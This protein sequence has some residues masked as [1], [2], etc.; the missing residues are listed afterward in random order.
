MKTFA[1]GITIG[2]VFGGANAFGS[3]LKSTNMLNSKLQEL[4]DKRI[5]LGSKFG[6]ASNEATK[7]NSTIIGLTRNIKLM[8][9]SFNLD[10][11]LSEYRKKFKESFVDKLALGTSIVMPFKVA[12]DFESAMADVKK[13]VNFAND[14]EFKDFEKS[15]LSLSQTIPLSATELAT[16]SASGGQLGIAKENLLE[17]TTTVAKMSTAFDMSA[18]HAGDSIAKLMNIYGL[19][20]SQIVE[21]GDSINHL[22]DTSASK[23]SD[24]VETLGRIG[25]VAKIFGLTTVQA[26]ALSSAFLSLGKPPEVAATSINALLLKLQTADK[27]GKS[28]N[29]GLKVLGLTAKQLKT[30]IEDNPQEAL[31][32]FLNT[33]KEVPKEDQ[34]GVLSDLFGAEYSDDIALLVGGLENYTSALDSVAD[35]T[36]YLGSMN[37]EF[38][39]RSKTSANNLK[40]L[41]N[42]I[43]KIAINFGTLLL[44]AL[45][46]VIAPLK[47]IG[48]FVGDFVVA[49]P[50]FSRVL[51]IAVVGAIALS[52]SFSAIG[53]MSSF[54][55]TGLL[56]VGRALIVLNSI[57]LANPIG[58][59]I[60]AIGLAVGLIY[61]YWEPIKTFFTNLWTDVS[62]IF[63]N[64]WNG[65]KSTISTFSNAVSNVFI[66][67]WSGI[68]DF[69]TSIWDGIKNIVNIFT[70]TISNI[71]ISAWSGITD[72]FTS[73]WDGIKNIFV[74]AIDVIKTYFGW[75]PI[76]M[77]MNNWGVITYFFKS[78]W[79]GTIQIFSNAWKSIK[80]IITD[81]CNIGK[82]IILTIWS[83]I[84]Y[85]F[86][87][88]WDGTIQV[89]SNAWT[90]I[91][92]IVID[93]SNI[94]KSIIVSIWSPIENFFSSLWNSVT[95]IFI[96]TWENIKN[97]FI[98]VVEFIKKPFE[99]F[100]NWL[101]SKFQWINELI[102]N[103]LGALANIGTTI[104]NKAVE[105]GSVIGDG[106]KSASQFFTIDHK[107]N[108]P[109]E[110]ESKLNYT[111]LPIDKKDVVNKDV[112]QTNH[113]QVTVNNPS[114]TV[115][116]QKGVTNALAKKTNSL[117]DEEL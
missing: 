115:D 29:E 79:N 93:V 15:L 88:L 112:Q 114:S 100:F 36:K 11:G 60:A 50:N 17:F 75:T 62:N 73:I 64:A 96:S 14:L 78:L 16:I 54:V 80:N 63:S 82:S 104:G 70:I 116:V 32:N 44:P 107:A 61:I 46:S 117:N 4:K 69:F 8:D 10:K 41:G 83:G 108:K 85:F 52:L 84:S 81:A 31:T 94:A 24:V 58:V 76:G 101:A 2:A 33:L 74:S 47:V 12:I 9:K 87:S 19:S 65:I 48:D 7:L 77:V 6:K 45:N 21:L 98:G 30:D 25:G 111:P 110:N 59:A 18:E 51:G 106:L 40:L 68:T 39:T 49:F 22:S 1:L 20:Q 28:F 90:G 97:S 38:E 103:T 71:F 67:A 91:K 37:K 5:D 89:F 109:A 3:A 72:F 43:T 99:D 102:S 105:M 55:I 26:G 92:N 34:M 23:A 53:F 86:T 113:I 35:K 42:T 27:Q 56:S 95:A 66:S 13:V 57:F